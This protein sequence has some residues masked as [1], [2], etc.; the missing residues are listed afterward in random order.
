M[1]KMSRKKQP[2]VHKEVHMVDIMTESRRKTFSGKRLHV[3]RFGL[4][5]LWLG[6]YWVQLIEL[7]K[8]VG[9]NCFIP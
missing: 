5:A 1:F 2:F 4:L 7:Y 6:I 9:G 8:E 3:L